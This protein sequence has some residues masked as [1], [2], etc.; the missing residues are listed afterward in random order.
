V[1][2]EERNEGLTQQTLT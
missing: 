2:G 1:N